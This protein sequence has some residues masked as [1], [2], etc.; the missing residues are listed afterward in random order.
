MS[1]WYLD[2][3][4]I[5]VMFLIAIPGLIGVYGTNP[6]FQW[7]V[8]TVYQPLDATVYSMIMFD[9]TLAFY[10]TFRAKTIDGA[11]L[12]ICAV[13]TML[14]NAPVTGV[15]LPAWIPIG[16]W[17]NNILV[18]AGSRAFLM[19]AAIGLVGFAIR[20]I[21]WQERATVGVEA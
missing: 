11:I 21:L 18:V 7:A 17:L 2:I 6:A 16:D 10:R 13:T 1:Y 19:V 9:A 5:V 12:L 3:W 15:L 14:R 8:T 4:T 20:T